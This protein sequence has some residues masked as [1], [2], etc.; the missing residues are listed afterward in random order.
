MALDG[1]ER[2]PPK[3]FAMLLQYQDN[4]FADTLRP[5][6]VKPEL[7]DA[8]QS[9]TRLEKQFCEIKVMRENDSIIFHGPP[10]DIRVRRVCRTQFTPMAGGV[11]VMVEIFNP[12]K[13]KTIVNDDGHAG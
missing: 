8:R 13:R 11:F 10:H 12:R 3:I 1:N 5:D 2:A 9:S 4:I 7:D 6:I